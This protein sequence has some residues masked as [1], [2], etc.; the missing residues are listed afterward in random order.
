MAIEMHDQFDREHEL[1]KPGVAPHNEVFDID[2]KSCTSGYM[3]EM[4]TLEEQA[5]V[6]EVGQAN[7]ELVAPRLNTNVLE[8]LNIRGSFVKYVFGSAHRCRAE[9]AS[10]DSTVIINSG[11]LSKP[12]DSLSQRG[13]VPFA[14]LVAQLH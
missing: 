6:I 3:T 1:T 11:D 14:P 2:E 12:L 7:N 8:V 9:S 4:S 5:Q 10:A 13:F